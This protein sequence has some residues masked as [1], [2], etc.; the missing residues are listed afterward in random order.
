MTQPF[1][2]SILYFTGSEMSGSDDS[3]N[4]FREKNVDM[5]SGT[6]PDES[7]DD[8]PS[9]PDLPK[10]TT[11]AGRKLNSDEE[12]E[13]FIPKELPKKDATAKSTA[14]ATSSKKKKVIRKEYAS[15]GSVRAPESARATMTVE[16]SK[17]SMPKKAGEK[18]RERT[19]YVKATV[20][21][22]TP[23]Y[24]DEEEEEEP[25]TKAPPKKKKK[26]MANA[27]PKDTSSKG[28]KTDPKKAAADKPRGSLETSQLLPRTRLLPLGKL[29]MMLCQL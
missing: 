3:Q 15:L 26:L 22:S 20:L 19:R 24:L 9:S 17:K 23:K 2:S 16:P 13:D 27:M 6:S 25:A 10:A 1:H 5:S 18:K 4:D 29:R 8:V 14:V 7:N 21:P 12:D 28:T 11:M